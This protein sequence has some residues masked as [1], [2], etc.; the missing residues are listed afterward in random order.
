MLGA[1]GHLERFD[2][3]FN[4]SVT[5]PHPGVSAD[6]IF[7]TYRGAQGITVWQVNKRHL[8]KSLRYIPEGRARAV[9]HH[10]PLATNEQAFVSHKVSIALDPK[11]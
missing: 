10:I 2:Y 9:A 8:F 3:N 7:A 4:G 6:L 1:A 11:I 5:Y